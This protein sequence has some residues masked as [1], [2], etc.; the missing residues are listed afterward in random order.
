MSGPVYGDEPQIMYEVIFMGV[1]CVIALVV[2]LPRRWY[3][4]SHWVP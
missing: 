1:A 4:S 3:T 2:W